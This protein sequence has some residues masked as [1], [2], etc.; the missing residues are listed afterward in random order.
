V[1]VAGFVV[2]AASPARRWLQVPA[3]ESCPGWQG[4]PACFSVLCVA[5]ALAQAA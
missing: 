2:F 5:G 3:V 1:L 4:R